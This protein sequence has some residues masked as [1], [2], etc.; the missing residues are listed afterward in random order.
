MDWTPKAACTKAVEMFW[1]EMNI[2][3]GLYYPED[4]FV[5]MY[6]HD[7]YKQCGTISQDMLESSKYYK[8]KVVRNPYNRAVSSYI[9]IMTTH[10][11]MFN[12]TN[13]RLNN[14]NVDKKSMLLDLSFEA[15]LSLYIDEIH[16]TAAAAAAVHSGYINEAIYHFKPQ[17][18]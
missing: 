6:R 12:G 7:F 5:H 15:F 11:E 17:A 8:F 14:A 1:N 13:L 18:S 3:R 4:A 10:L 9:H 2:T 16:H